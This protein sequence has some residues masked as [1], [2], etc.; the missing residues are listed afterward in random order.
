MASY[1]LRINVTKSLLGIIQKK[2]IEEHNP[3]WPVK[4]P[5]R[6]LGMIAEHAAADLPVFDIERYQGNP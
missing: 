4:L 1:K 2:S 5:L 3:M 6:I